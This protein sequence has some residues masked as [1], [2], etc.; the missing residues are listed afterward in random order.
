MT[1]FHAYLSVERKHE[2]VEVAA[3]SN[4]VHLAHD[5]TI[6]RPRK[7]VYWRKD[8][9]VDYNISRSNVRGERTH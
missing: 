6:L 4:A 8:E 5:D 9:E 2:K 3:I 1:H 7:Y